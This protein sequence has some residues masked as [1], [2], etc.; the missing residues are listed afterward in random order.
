MRAAEWLSFAGVMDKLVE[1]QERVK[2]APSATEWQQAFRTTGLIPEMEYA[3]ANLQGIL[4][5]LGVA[6]LPGLVGGFEH[7]NQAMDW[8]RKGLTDKNGNAT[9]FATNLAYGG[10]ALGAAL[11]ARMMWKFGKFLVGPSGGGGGGAAATTA[12]SSLAMAILRPLAIAKVASELF[13]GFSPFPTQGDVSKGW[14]GNWSAEQARNYQSQ[15]NWSWL[16]H[17]I[18]ELNPFRISPA[19]GGEPGVGAGGKGVGQSR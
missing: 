19:Y 10:E 6:T 3:W 11:F 16:G 8:I 18:S 4:T 7:L 5:T 13:D 1:L 12:G 17:I 9:P 2:R 14:K 15:D